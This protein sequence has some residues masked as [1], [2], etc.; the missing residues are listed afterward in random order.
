MRLL[1]MSNITKKEIKV[2]CVVGN[3]PLYSLHSTGCNLSHIFLY[4]YYYYKLWLFY[5]KKLM[6]IINRD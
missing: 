4:Y 6:D 5:K 3:V 1:K 2:L